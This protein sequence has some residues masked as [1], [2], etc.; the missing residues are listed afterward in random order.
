MSIFFIL[1]SYVNVA[2]QIHFALN[3]LILAKPA[4]FIDKVMRELYDS[5]LKSHNTFE[6]EEARSYALQF[7][8]KEARYMVLFAYSDVFATDMP[9]RNWTPAPAVPVIPLKPVTDLEELA[10]LYDEISE[11]REQTGGRTASRLTF[12]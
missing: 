11:E 6:P 4:D 1:E 3:D 12:L 7:L 8:Y 10:R 5:H 2:F 9:G